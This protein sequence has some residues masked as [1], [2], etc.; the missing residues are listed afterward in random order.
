MFGFHV[1]LWGKQAKSPEAR[2]RELERKEKE[3][4]SETEWKN[5][6]IE[7]NEKERRKKVCRRRVTS[8]GQKKDG[9][10]KT[11]SSMWKNERIEERRE[12]TE[13]TARTLSLRNEDKGQGGAVTGLC[14]VYLCLSSICFIPASSNHH[15]SFSSTLTILFLFLPE[16]RQGGL[17]NA[18]GLGKSLTP[19]S[20]SMTGRLC[21]AC[22]LVYLINVCLLC[23]CTQ[24]SLS[25]PLACSR[26][27][28]YGRSLSNC[29][30]AHMPTLSAWSHWSLAGLI[31]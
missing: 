8:G 20:R 24:Q 27:C 29:S 14:T 9:V 26:C 19:R 7:E 15:L 13:R 3:K 16:R 12:Q 5:G 17:H 25:E 4:E 11:S 6:T 18:R 22:L 10:K 28:L 21:S 30:S 1:G 31:T 2:V 23:E